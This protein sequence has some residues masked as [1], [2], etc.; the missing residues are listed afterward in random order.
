MQLILF[1]NDIHYIQQ[2]EHT[3][4]TYQYPYG[5]GVEC[6][7][8]DSLEELEIMH[9]EKK[10]SYERGIFAFNE[11]W[12]RG[13]FETT[14]PL[15]QYYL[16]HQQ[17]CI[18]SEGIWTDESTE[19]I[20][21]YY[22]KQKIP[23]RPLSDQVI[24]KYQSA[25]EIYHQIKS[26]FI[27]N[28][29]SE[30]VSQKIKTAFITLYK[31]YGTYSFSDEILDQ[32][33]SLHFSLKNKKILIIHYDSFF[34]NEKNPKSNLSYVYMQIRNKKT[35]FRLILNEIV[36]KPYRNIDVLEGALNM[37]DY[38]F[39]TEQEEA[40]WLTWLKEQS[41]YDVVVFTLNGVHINQKLHTL[42]CRSERNILFSAE[43]R[44]QQS[45]FEQIDGKWHIGE[46]NNTSLVSV[47]IEKMLQEKEE[48]YS[49]E[50]S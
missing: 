2:L 17:W 4:C 33:K 26:N 5:G 34:H 30:I 44:I 35:N 48:V 20:Q 22:K 8:I 19:H 43:E 14:N 12:I 18:L 3:L 50:G 11:E 24:H 45:V 36:Q 39:L 40:M 28:M 31:P 25:S 23:M 6:I 27:Q 42:I 7:R 49:N 9:Q 10:I 16:Q 13:V 15:V 32:I 41:G 38:D 21:A 29:N 1:D 47:S 37:R 46:S